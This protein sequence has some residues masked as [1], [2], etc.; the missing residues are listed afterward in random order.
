MA[1]SS[2]SRRNYI[3]NLT[4]ASCKA[5]FLK[6]VFT[7][8]I[9]VF[10]G[11]P[12]S[13]YDV[14]ELLVRL[15]SAHNLEVHSKSLED[16]TYRGEEG[17]LRIRP[18]T[19]MDLG[20]VVHLSPEFEQGMKL[21]DEADKNLE[22]AKRAMRTQAVEKAPGD[23]ARTIAERFLE[24]KDKI[25][26]AQTLLRTYASEL[27]ATVDERLNAM[28][29]EALAAELLNRCLAKTGNRLRDALGCFAN[30]CQ[31]V[32]SPPF[33]TPENVR[34]VNS[35]FQDF[36]KQAPKEL[37]EGLDLDRL[38]PRQVTADWKKATGAEEARI[39]PHLETGLQKL[40]LDHLV[41]VDPLL[42]LALIRRESQFDPRAISHMGAAGLTQIMPKTAE[43]MGMENIYR[44][45]YF[46]KAF[47][48]LQEERDARRA[49]MDALFAITPE[50]RFENAAR[51]RERMQASIRL[52]RERK[53]FFSRYRK[54]LRMQSSDPRLQPAK[55]V[56]YG[57][58]YFST[59]M[60]QQEK[61]ISLALASYNA[62]PHRVRQY[63]G[64]P[65]YAETVRF[66]NRV[67]E[68]YREYL[69]K[70]DG[71]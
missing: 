34:F 44:P 29:C 52:S 4:A 65:P 71:K 14:P 24:H 6:L 68:F 46:D 58:R 30:I 54:E 47:S 70:L 11:V 13:A 40:D 50:N 5:T 22:A 41:S 21:F 16:G 42:F 35:I 23:Y 49:A 25:L 56:E 39:V 28:R 33:L 60:N 1:L 3:L 62:G 32:S 61:D 55:A 69:D 9:V 27:D 67:L 43:K 64:I 8:V 36:V 38:D 12:A 7:L 2:M 59:L 66:R 20:L 57:L 15:I 31:G 18:K 63:Q 37:L 48:L 17:I 26:K 45:R 53:S 10:H 19:G 51:A